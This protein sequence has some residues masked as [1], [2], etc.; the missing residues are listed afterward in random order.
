MPGIFIGIGGIGG[1]IVAKLDEALRVRV[2]LAGE[3]PSAREAAD[4]FR[5]LLLDTWKD[6]VSAGFDASQVLDL[7]EGKDKFDVD[8]KVESWWR[9]GDNAFRNWWPQ[10]TLPGG[11][12]GAPLLAGPYASG[13]GQLRVKGRLAYRISLTG[14]GRA[15]ED[16]VQEN[17]R[18]ISAVL[19][20]AAGINTVPVYLVS[21][22]GG[23]S[24]SGMVLT[25][26]QHLR[27]TLPEYCP[28]I[29]VFPLAS[30][31]EMGPGAADRSSIWANTDSALREIDY[32]QRVAG[33][34][35]NVL[36]P[37]FQ[38]PGQGNVIYG[39]KRPFEYVYLFGRDNQSGQS[40]GEFSSYIELMTEALIAES[41][42]SL[43]DE[44]LQNAI[45]GPHSQFIMQL[46]AR[47]EV[48]GRPTTYASASI[49][50]LVFPSERVERHLARRF[51]ID[52]LGRMTEFDETFVNAGMQDFLQTHALMWTGKPSFGA[53]FVNKPIT[54]HPSGKEKNFPAF[55]S[56]ITMDPGSDFAKVGSGDVTTMATAAMKALDIMAGKQW[57]HHFQQRR[58]EI[59]EAYAGRAGEPGYLRE[60]VVDTL[61]SGRPDALGSAYEIVA[62]ISLQLEGQ[63]RLLNELIEGNQDTGAPGLRKI[64]ERTRSAYQSA[65]K[66]LP[67]GYGSG[68]TAIFN[69]DGKG[70]KEDF[71]TGPY[72]SL[73][74]CTR[75]FQLMI[76]ARQ[77]YRDLG[78]ETG[79]MLRVLRD[80]RDTALLLRDQ[81]ER[82]TRSDVGVHGRTGVLD[83]AVLDDPRLLDHHF[84][85][86]LEETSRTGVN[87]C[88][89]LVTAPTR[90][91]GTAGPFA[92][93]FDVDGNPLD[94]PDAL[95]TTGVVL[96]TFNRMLDPLVGSSTLTRER[97]RDQLAQGIVAD[98]VN[99]LGSRVRDMSI[100]DALAAE[101]QARTAL[102]MH[103]AAVEQADRDIK[104]QRQNAEDAGVP[105]RDWEQE[106]LRFFIRRRLEEVQKRVRP[107]WNL[108]GLMTANHGQA[109]GFVVL[110][111]D[112]K[113]YE[114]A[115][116][117]HGIKGVLGII[118]SLMQ[119]GT[120]K[121]LNGPDRIVLYSREGVVPL[122]YLNDR[123]LK[124]MRDSSAQKA[125]DKFL[126]TDARF[127]ACV[128]P[129]IRPEQTEDEQFLYAMGLALQ[130][131]VIQWERAAAGGGVVTLHLGDDLLLTSSL[132]ELADTLRADLPQHTAFLSRINAIMH[133]L[134]EDQQQAAQHR[135]QIAVTELMRA[136]GDR[137]P[138]EVDLGLLT[139]IEEA[140]LLRMN[141]GQ[142][143]V[144]E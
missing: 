47:P 117:T 99:R 98:G 113:A 34:P 21:S 64:L 36:S 54:E 45:R 52:V 100:W 71:V 73:V 142:P 55:T 83:L 96:E 101:C 91:S 26:A 123:E 22:L 1:S 103:D 49:A 135:A 75:D 143:F 44:G 57:E 61:T 130:L 95:A 67:D 94:Q 126:Y 16:A 68:L 38:W 41:F 6:G 119:A 58:K 28:L 82:E 116:T 110:A 127:A 35:D 31:T 122:F 20:P 59:R 17:L 56:D 72:Q 48:G 18:E 85:N 129:V 11:E 121:W 104:K 138:G 134:S 66:D 19:G 120:P 107:F 105:P 39:D 78:I 13:A 97:Y 109:Y 84:H 2:A 51:A 79:R 102:N 115:E 133:E 108:N 80:L 88:A 9:G 90:D 63:F 8:A 14:Q 76:V 43:T 93:S 87:E 77:A 132:T 3:S 40:L 137:K 81:L 29:G 139:S 86:L 33:T 141:Y 89:I 15:A 37:F 23:G 32:C 62:G 27:Q 144:N 46:Q 114:L 42:H 106:V 4:Q 92:A 140:I 118:T 74:E 65:A 125:R 136:D 60:A 25:F 112:R 70:A 30:V 128:D 24:G 7:P 124:V 10:R 5:F 12:S 53:E 69:R 50:S 111:T 131:G